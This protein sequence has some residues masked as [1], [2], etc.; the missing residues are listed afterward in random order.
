MKKETYIRKATSAK[1]EG[2]TRVYFELLGVADAVEF[3]AEMTEAEK[4]ETY[5]AIAEIAREIGI[6]EQTIS[7]DGIWNFQNPIM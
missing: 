7:D 4:A 3:D 1:I 6:S 5:R 2:I